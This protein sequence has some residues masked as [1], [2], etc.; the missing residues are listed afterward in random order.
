MM[1]IFS[2]NHRHGALNAELAER[3]RSGWEHVDVSE[4]VSANQNKSLKNCAG[5]IG[6]YGS[7]P[8]AS[9]SGHRVTVGWSD[10]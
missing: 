9:R 1:R 5:L 7:S 4:R 10:K 6:P 3:A 8:G 2:I